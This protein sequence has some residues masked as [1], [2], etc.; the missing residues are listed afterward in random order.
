MDDKTTPLEAGL[1]WTVKFNK[2]DFRGRE[3]LLKQKIEGPKKLLALLVLDTMDTLPAA[4]ATVRADGRVV[5]RVTSAEFG[6]S[7]ERALVFAKL[8]TQASTDGTVIEVEAPNGLWLTGFVSN[9][10]PYDPTGLKVRS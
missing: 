6:Y 10:P 9:K 2:P 3:A 8:D 1:A 7:V 5:G 4:G